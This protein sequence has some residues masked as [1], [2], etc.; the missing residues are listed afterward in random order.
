MSCDT[1]RPVGFQPRRGSKKRGWCHSRGSGN[2]NTRNK[3]AAVFEC[4]TCSKEYKTEETYKI[5][6][7]SHVKVCVSS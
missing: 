3:M 6:L 5:H 1:V 2:V 7:Q 4:K